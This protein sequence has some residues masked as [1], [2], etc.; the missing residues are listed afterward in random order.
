MKKC[1]VIAHIIIIIIIVI[2][3]IGNG[4]SPTLEHFIYNNHHK[5]IPV[6]IVLVNHLNEMIFKVQKKKNKRRIKQ[7]GH[8][9][10]KG[11]WLC[12]VYIYYKRRRH[13]KN[14]SRLDRFQFCPRAQKQ[15]KHIIWQQQQHIVQHI[16]L[17][18][19]WHVKCRE[20]F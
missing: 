8:W 9:I 12:Y 1:S 17:S 6:L 19:Y 2:I 15:N 3:I 5:M 7:S 16:L 4:I 18:A 20:T 11:T 10:T 13:V 14:V